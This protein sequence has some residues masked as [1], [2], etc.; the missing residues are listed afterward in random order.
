[1][2]FEANIVLEE[3][4]LQTS[5]EDLLAAIEGYLGPILCQLQDSLL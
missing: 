2:A 4:K 3:K 1:M 5:F